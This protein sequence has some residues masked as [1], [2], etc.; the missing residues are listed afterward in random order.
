[1]IRF[2]HGEE[3]ADVD[4]TCECG[5]T[6]AVNWDVDSEG[7]ECVWLQCTSCRK[8]RHV[9]DNGD[10]VCEHKP[11]EDDYL[12]YNPWAGA[13]GEDPRMFVPRSE[14]KKT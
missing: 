3:Y 10:W 8:T 11:R 1:M 4:S 5:E 7:F 2:L 12:V 14:S 6:M 9:I 13:P